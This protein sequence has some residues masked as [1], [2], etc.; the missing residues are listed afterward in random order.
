M[1]PLDVVLLIFVFG[2]MAIA[3]GSRRP[4]DILPGIGVSAAA[5]LIRVSGKL[6]DP[7]RQHSGHRAAMGAVYAGAGVGRRH[8]RV[9]YRHVG[10][11]YALAPAVESQEN[12]GRRGG[13]TCLLRCWWRYAFAGWLDAD[14]RP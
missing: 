13:E 5:L 2:C 4:A 14:D 9:F 11:A 6:S 10:G 12:M 8:R 3:L 1:L 7:F